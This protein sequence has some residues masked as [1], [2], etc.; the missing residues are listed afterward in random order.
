MEAN[1][2]A[3]HAISPYLP[4]KVLQ[5]LRSTPVDDLALDNLVRLI[6]GAEPSPHSTIDVRGEWSAQ[7][8]SIAAALS[9]FNRSS[10]NKRSLEDSESDP[11]AKRPRI[12]PPEATAPPPS[13]DVNTGR[14]IFALSPISTTAPVRKKADL[15]VRENTLVFVNSTTKALDT[16]PIPLSILRRA[17][18]LP[19]RGKTKPHWTVVI[20]SADS[21]SSTRVKQ[22][23]GS[24]DEHPQIVFGVDAKVT[25]VLSTTIYDAEGNPTTTAHPKS[26]ESLP[27]L[28]EFLSHLRIP[29]FEPTPNVFKSAVPGLGKN[30]NPDGV[31]G[32]EAYRAAKPGSLW[33][34][35]EGILWGE[36]K[37]CEFW[38]VEDFIGRTEGLKI[39]GGVGKTCSVILT[40]RSRPSPDDK[41][42]KN[43]SEEAS[44]D[45][46]E[47]D[48]GEETE[49]S[50]IDSKEK[51]GIE[52]WVKQ[53]R[54]LFGTA[55]G[56]TPEEPPKAE[57]VPKG[58]LTIHHLGDETDESDE[59][60]T[61]SSDNDSSEGSNA[62]E[63]DEDSES[64][65]EDEGGE[66]GEDEA[67][68][69][70]ASGEGES[71]EELDPKHHPL[72]RAGALP[73]MSKAVMDMAVGMVVDDVVGGDSDEEVDELME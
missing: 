48:F 28:R 52:V 6:G 5:G 37:P 22:A 60:F 35:R 13:N 11:A 71:E 59:D 34:M 27:I 9:S 69:S 62:D 64:Q 70:V 30:A 58:P 41:E 20:L 15:N 38:A 46:P 66:G 72:L 50:M 16:P 31:P 24:N 67:E 10:D 45:E 42:G 54:H 40:R 68:A 29:V 3:F 57:D 21:Q 17:F 39:I 23:K 73:R 25:T 26:T 32:I 33:F 4:E 63:S 53:Y 1:A 49:F 47:E 43:N 19:T 36:S 44:M 65:E 55:G 12:S 51:E 2:N 61:A 18:L 8:T 56:R 7:Q 14:P